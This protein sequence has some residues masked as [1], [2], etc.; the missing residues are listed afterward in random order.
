MLKPSGMRLKELSRLLG[1]SQTTV[2]R[3]L[4]G[5]PEVS[6]ET[7]ARVQQAA[8]QHH[9]EPSS[10]ARRLA[11]GRSMTIGHVV[12][13]ARHAMINPHF[14]DFIAGAGETYARHGYDMLISVV[15]EAE[16]ERVYRALAAEHKVDG[17]IVHGPRAGD[18][19]IALA[20]SLG[21]PFVVHGRSD[22]V[23][24]EYSWLDVNNRRSFKRATEFLTD[25]GHRRIALLNGLE[26]M[27]F[28]SR[29]K[30]GFLD[31]LAERGIDADPAL[32]TSDEMIEPNGYLRARQMLALPQPPTAILASSVLLA[33]GVLRAVQE[34]GLRPGR[35]ISILTHDDELS[36]LQNQGGVPVFTAV[37]SSIRRAGERCA[38]MVIRLANE[39]ESGPLQELWECELVVG[40]ST[41]PAA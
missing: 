22:D 25:L 38:E 4:N 19:R 35:D 36:F 2:S 24:G 14:A 7:R 1:L 6:E 39:P 41:G 13:L 10:A 17:V 23:D 21:L 28:A 30:R 29:R 16:E 3:A 15:A 31:A 34:A 26:D 12:P 40:A 11:T 8:R 5:Y 20:R 37:R 33:M 18:P 27:N 32:M 9:Y